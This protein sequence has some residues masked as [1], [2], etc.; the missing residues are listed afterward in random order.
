MTAP[1][2]DNTVAEGSINWYQQKMQ[3]A[4]KMINSAASDEA[5]ASAQKMYDEYKSKIDQLKRIAEIDSSGELNKAVDVLPK[6]AT[7]QLEKLRGKQISLISPRDLA[8]ISGITDE[9]TYLETLRG[10]SLISDEELAKMDE[11]NAKLKEMKANIPLTPAEKLAK[12]GESASEAW[13]NAGASIQTVGGA[14]QSIDNP[15]AQV[16]GMIAEAIATV[17]L[18]FAK[19]LKG[20]MTPWDWIAAAA[21]G[22]A[23]MIST[24]AAI[25]SATAGTYANG[26][27]V[28]G[29][30]YSGDNLLVGVNSGEVILNQAQSA[31]LASKLTS[32]TEGGGEC[33]PYLDGETVWLGLS[34]HLKRTGKGEIVTSRR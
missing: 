28:G 1:T 31:N 9:L 4:G 10:L 32:G 27:I 34:R 26:G 22:T 30:S 25:K 11:L 8:T 24:I 2:V 18:T 19:S 29:S 33:R 7:E 12:S 15:M 23:T 6:D 17:A 21:A 3:E 5:R 20:T 16:I 13:S 14:L